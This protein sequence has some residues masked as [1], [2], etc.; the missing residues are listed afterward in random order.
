VAQTAN[1]CKCT[2]P[3]PHK[4]VALHTP[5][6]PNYNQLVGDDIV[7]KF[8]E[9]WKHDYL[10]PGSTKDNLIVK[11]DEKGSQRDN[12]TT[13]EAISY[14]MIIE[15]LM[16]GYDADAKLQFDKLY[17]YALSYPSARSKFLMAWAQDKNFENVGDDS[18][19]DGD[20]DIA[21]ALLMAYIQWNDDKYKLAA[22]STIVAITAQEIDAKNLKIIRGNASVPS[23]VFGYHVIRISDFMPAEFRAFFN[24]TGQHIWLDLIET[25]Y[26]RYQNVQDKFSRTFGL[27]PDY[28]QV[29][30]DGSLSLVPTDVPM[31][32]LN[33]EGINDGGDNAKDNR[34]GRLYGFNSCRVPWRIATDFLLNGNTEAK[35]I[36]D[37]INAGIRKYSVDSAC[38]LANI[39]VLDD[40]LSPAEHLKRVTEAARKHSADLSTIGPLCISAL[41]NND[42]TVWRRHLLGLLVEDHDWVCENNDKP[43]KPNYYDSTIRMICLLLLSKDY[44]LPEN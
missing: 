41:A 33:D 14:G 37:K 7:T 1:D 3:F 39:M 2:H 11:N 20:V 31:K 32:V 19:V 4:S 28:I 35:K 8:Y 15:V 16:A 44:W 5:E 23:D 21:F 26:K 22:D 9:I 27:F 25:N 43:K 18:A 17:R 30:D 12:I 38:L 13:S 42:Q 36:L 6:T 10:R 40:S 29:A 24:S 34:H